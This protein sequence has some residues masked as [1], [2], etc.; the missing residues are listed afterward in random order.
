MVYF[1]TNAID[2]YITDIDNIVP[3]LYSSIPLIKYGNT[4]KFTGR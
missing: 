3:I 1:L 2:V 4:K